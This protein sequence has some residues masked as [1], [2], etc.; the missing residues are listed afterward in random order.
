MNNNF[1]ITWFCPSMSVND[2][3]EYFDRLSGLYSLSF[4]CVDTIHDLYT[5][6]NSED[7]STNYI[8]IELEELH[9][10]GNVNSFEILK[11]LE[12]ML[13]VNSHISHVNRPHIIGVVGLKTSTSLIKDI[14]RTNLLSGLI[15]KNDEGVSLQDIE[16]CFDKIIKNDFTYHKKIKYLLKSKKQK[17]ADITVS[18]T[19]RQ[20]QIFDLVTTRGS[21]NK[22]IAKTL[23]ITESTVKLHMGAI[24]KKFNAKSRTQLVA[25]SK[26]K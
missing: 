20:K 13:M 12:T 17:N 19:P 8:C 1:L 9:N 22:V 2:E 10:L 7:F 15:L 24:L 16:E 23:N 6:V 18:L 25:F 5:L 21:S 3:K 26:E 11:A 14:L 4:V